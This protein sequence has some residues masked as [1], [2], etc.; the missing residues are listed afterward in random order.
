[1]RLIIRIVLALVVNA[2][3]LL[4]A[5]SVVDGVSIDATY[6]VI[7]VTIFTIVSLF[8]RPLLAFVIARHL[9]PLL[10]IIGLVTT[11]L[12]LLITDVLSDGINIDGAT[13]WILATVIVWIAQMLYEIFDRRIQLMVMRMIRPGPA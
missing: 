4:I 10:G 3:A 6:F 8:L 1:M 12:I 5:A 13:A 7:A 9:R 2:I 11:F